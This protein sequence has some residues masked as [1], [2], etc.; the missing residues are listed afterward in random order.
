MRMASLVFRLWVLLLTV[1]LQVGS[2]RAGA[3]SS[4]SRSTTSIAAATPTAFE[5]FGMPAQD[6]PEQGTTEQE[7][8]SDELSAVDDMFDGM[9][10]GS[11]HPGC[12][13]APS[14][15]FQRTDVGLPTGGPPN[16][17]PFKPP[18]A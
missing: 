15:R 2:W 13:P 16:D 17:A 10:A 9:L 14:T 5:D 18:R 11:Y 12:A 3:P 4:T 1:L 7:D 6:A 8:G